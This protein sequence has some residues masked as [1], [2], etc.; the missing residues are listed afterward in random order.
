MLGT[1]SNQ[2]AP[3]N[4]KALVLKTTSAILN[5]WELFHYIM[6]FCCVVG[7]RINHQW[8]QASSRHD[9]YFCQ[10]SIGLESNKL[11]L[12]SAGNHSSM[13]TIVTGCKPSLE[14]RPPSRNLSTFPDTYLDSKF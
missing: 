3:G 5:H 7:K 6:P 2:S 9:V 12:C 4:G 13:S 8:K 11:L 14:A 1:S 10:L